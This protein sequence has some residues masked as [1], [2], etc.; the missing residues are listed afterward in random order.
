[1]IKGL[2]FNGIRPLPAGTFLAF[3]VSLTVPFIPFGLFDLR[4]PFLFFANYLIER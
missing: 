1:M 2:V 4:L 3:T